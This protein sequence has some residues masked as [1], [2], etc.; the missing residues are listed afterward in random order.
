V[1]Q[2][3]RTIV[4]GDGFGRV[5]FLRLEGAAG[6]V[7]EGIKAT[8]RLVDRS[9]NG[10]RKHILWVDDRPGNNIYE[11]R[12]FE[13]MGIEFTLALSTHEA[14]NLLSNKRFA[15]I[16]SDMGRKEGP[17]EGYVLL[18]A[19]RAKDR[20]TPF[21]IYAGSN[22]PAHKRGA[23]ERGAQGS[24]NRAQELFD[25]VIQALPTNDPA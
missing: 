20:E 8:E 22:D 19:V 3:N 23:I 15:A 7:L 13:S 2:D 5:H 4:A 16:I 11:R 21:F 17:K 6:R 14:L 24:T 12:A 18:D 10:W 9:A 1:A 25:M